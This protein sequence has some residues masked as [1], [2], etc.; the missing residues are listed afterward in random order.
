M[1]E[2]FGRRCTRPNSPALEAGSAWAARRSTRG[3]CSGCAT[4]EMGAKMNYEGKRVC[5]VPRE[6]SSIKKIMPPPRKR[7]VTAY[8]AP[9]GSAIFGAM[10]ND[11]PA[12]SKA[13]SCS[14]EVGV[15]S[16]TK[17]LPKD[18]STLKIRPEKL[19]MSVDTPG[20]G[21]MRRIINRADFLVFQSSNIEKAFW[22][23]RSHSSH[24]FRAIPQCVIAQFFFI[25]STWSFQASFHFAMP[26]YVASLRPQFCRQK[27]WS[28]QPVEIGRKL[29]SLGSQ[30][31]SPRHVRQRL[32]NLLGYSG[33]GLAPQPP[34]RL[35]TF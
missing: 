22:W 24:H 6:K 31:K 34:E 7:A 23:R 9:P 29:A 3:E 19:A 10:A 25:N 27:Q 13:I 12:K 21:L 1:A 20:G 28:A 14:P 33:A 8:E 35:G 11:V 16:I 2:W 32:V 4:A 18:A 30:G 15:P 5:Q 17:T 26:S